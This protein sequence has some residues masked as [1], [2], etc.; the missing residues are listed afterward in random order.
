[1]DPGSRPGDRT[2]SAERPRLSTPVDVDELGYATLTEAVRGLLG[3][4]LSKYKRPQVWRRVVGF[5][6][7]RGYS[8]VGALMATCRQDPVLRG[9][10]RDML[11][12]N[13][14]EFFRNPDAWTVLQTRFL[15]SIVAAGRGPG[16]SPIR[17]WSAGCSYGY[18]PYSLAM[19]LLEGRSPIRTEILATDVDE[20]ILARARANRY[21]EAQMAG[22]STARRDRFFRSDAGAW[23]ARPELQTMVTWRVHD[24]LC[25]PVPGRFDLIA[26][27]NVAIYFTDAAKTELYQGF[28]ASLNPNGL[29]FVG[30][31]ESIPGPGRVGLASV[32]PGFYR[33]AD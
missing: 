21:D 3:L 11:T 16:S 32:A 23:V 1:M 33:R 19:Q 31:T 26:C 20:P 10:F 8:D 12:I 24:L 15:P 7:A 2:G 13:V 9:S 17:V 25:D 22:V 27:R 6:A 14:S 29:L 30:A 28:A 18:E 5:A 4:D